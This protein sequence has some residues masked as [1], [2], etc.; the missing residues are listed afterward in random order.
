[1][2]LKLSVAAVV[3]NE[4]DSLLEWIAYHRVVGVEHFFI[5]NN[6]STDGTKA[7]LLEL[8]EKGLVTLV[9]LRTPKSGNVQ[10][11]AYSVLLK[12]ARATCDLLAFIDADEYLLP[13]DGSSSILP[14]L[15]ERFN[16]DQVSALGLNWANF[17]SNNQLFQEEGLVIERFTRRAKFEFG[18]HFHIKTI[19]RPERIKGFT[20]PHY[21]NLYYGQY[22]D[23]EGNEITP[24]PK[25]GKGLSNKV[26]WHR[27][28]VNHY[29]TKSLEEFLLGKSRRG[30]ATKSYRVKHKKYYV[31]HDKN[32][33]IC[34]IAKKISLKVQAERIRITELDKKYKLENKQSALKKIKNKL[35]K[36]HRYFFKIN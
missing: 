22:V 36:Y 2:S 31:S 21:V 11:P 26:T 15:E 17:G 32:D 24:H 34:E 5:A 19:A 8:Q 3:K 25:H 9:N 6:E 29:P 7:I 16:N 18:V 28:R 23:T 4:A 35:S 33:E 12:A 13:T 30:S 14:L 27:A 20:N 1:V 10:I